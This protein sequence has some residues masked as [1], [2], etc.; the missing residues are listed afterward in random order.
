MSQYTTQVTVASQFVLFQPE[1]LMQFHLNHEA[2]LIKSVLF[3]LLLL[4]GLW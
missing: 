2:T 4:H 3:S 1:A